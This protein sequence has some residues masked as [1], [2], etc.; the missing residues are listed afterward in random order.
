VLDQSIV[1]PHSPSRGCA[2]V[3]SI[4]SSAIASS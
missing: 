2:D 1:A 4:A 3:Y